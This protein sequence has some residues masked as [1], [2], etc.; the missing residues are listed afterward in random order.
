MLMFTLQANRFS[1]VEGHH[2]NGRNNLALRLETLQGRSRCQ[3][4]P[5]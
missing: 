2:G 5:L 4:L 1:A 3:L